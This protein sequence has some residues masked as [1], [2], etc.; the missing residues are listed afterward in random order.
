MRQ[1]AGD[2]SAGPGASF[3]VPFGQKL[4][5]GG[6]GGLPR[7][8]EIARQLP[9]GREPGAGVRAS[10][11]DHL[12]ESFGQLLV[13]RRAGSAV[14]AEAEQCSLKIGPF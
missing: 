5:E 12:S 1:I 8:G 7:D 9:A 4:V 14:E 11:E 10:R 6:Q 13:Q 2:I 3:Q